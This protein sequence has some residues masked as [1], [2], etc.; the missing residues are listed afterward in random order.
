[1]KFCFVKENQAIA[2][3][4]DYFRKRIIGRLLAF[5]VLLRR[6]EL[7]GHVFLLSV[8]PKKN[9]NFFVIRKIKW[10]FDFHVL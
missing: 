10:P 1:M 7:G 2:Q 9:M 6:V 4:S 3:L 5:H 8:W